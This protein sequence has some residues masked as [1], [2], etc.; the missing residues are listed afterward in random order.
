MRVIILADGPAVRW[1]DHPVPKHLVAIR[2]EALLHRTVRQLRYRGLTDIWIT[3]HN[4][5]YEVEG[6]RRFEPEDNV[7][8]IDQFYA[9][10]TLWQGQ[11]EPVVFL[12]GDVYFSDGAVDIIVG[13]SPPDYLYFQRTGPSQITGKPWKEGFAMVVADTAVFCKALVEIRTALISGEAKSDHHQ[14]Q[15]YLEGHGLGEYWGIGPHGVEIDDATDDFDVPDD[16]QVWL[17]HTDEV[18]QG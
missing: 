18:G 12:Y 13:S 15:G 9:C 16:I 6:T 1:K 3:S 7:F 10:R 8:Q 14:L 4:E 2:G 17:D 11:S 5:S